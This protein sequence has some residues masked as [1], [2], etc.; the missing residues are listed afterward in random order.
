MH[1]QYNNCKITINANRKQKGF[2][3]S[4][5]FSLRDKRI[6]CNTAGTEFAKD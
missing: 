6:S 3:A 2:L 5:F 1:K 4:K